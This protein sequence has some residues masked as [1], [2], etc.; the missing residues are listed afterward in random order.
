METL[1]IVIEEYPDFLKMC[2]TLKGDFKR[3]VAEQQGSW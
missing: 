1:K 3:T 2:A